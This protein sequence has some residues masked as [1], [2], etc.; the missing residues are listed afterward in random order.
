MAWDGDDL[1]NIVRAD[2]IGRYSFSGLPNG[3]YVVDARVLSSAVT[4]HSGG[5]ELPIYEEN[6]QDLIEYNARITDG[7][8]T[9]LDLKI[10][11][12]W[13]SVIHGKIHVSGKRKLPERLSFT[14]RIIDVDGV[15]R[16]ENYVNLNSLFVYRPDNK[17]IDER[18][19]CFRYID[20]RGGSY[21]IEV[22]W[23][24]P[25]DWNI[26]EKK[27]SERIYNN[28]R[29][30]VSKTFHVEPSSDVRHDIHLALATVQ[31]QIVDGT[32]G[33][34]KGHARFFIDPLNSKSK[35]R[36]VELVT[37]HDGSFCFRNIPAG[38]FNVVIY[39]ESYVPM[40]INSFDVRDNDNKAGLKYELESGACT[41]SGS[42]KFL[43]D[44]DKRNFVESL[45]RSHSSWR[46]SPEIQPVGIVR[47]ESGELTEDGSFNLRGLPHGPVKLV[48]TRGKQVKA[49][50]NVV[51]PLAEGEQ[52]VIEVP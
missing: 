15:A 47:L 37:K 49:E 11:E 10:E 20:T 39:H 35:D 50:R 5:V 16:L 42:V 23:C 24:E 8:E 12:P 38:I 36:L 21:K 46:V 26:G 6:Y 22:T 2:K 1:I 41:V 45:S 30:S 43:D 32:T 52:L 17:N 7:K 19:G 18:Q 40:I 31:G 34:S 51:L 33:L 14:L 9:R 48:V 29:W 27:S 3:R 28:Q 13:N 25:I 44:K 4:D